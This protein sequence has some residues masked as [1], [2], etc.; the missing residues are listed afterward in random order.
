MTTLSTSVKTTVE[1][2]VRTGK[3][4]DTISLGHGANVTSVHGGSG[5]DTIII[6]GPYRVEYIGDSTKCAVIYLDEDG[7]DTANVLI[8][9][10]SSTSPVSQK[11]RTSS[12]RTV[13]S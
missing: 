2:T 4:D 10:R 5:F 6:D 13:M 11:G 3:G 1:G 7:N 9:D 8:F 12:V